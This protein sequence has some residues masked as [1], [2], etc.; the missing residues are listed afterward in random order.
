MGLRLIAGISRPSTGMSNLDVAKT[1]LEQLGGGRFIAMTGARDFLGDANSLKFRLPKAKD[2]I[3]CVQITLE[4]SDTY[5]VK[6]M[7]IGDRRT[8]YRVT[9]KSVHE[10][11]YFDQ[12][13]ELF[14]RQTGL[15]THL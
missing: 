2:G 15:Y 13:Q 6:F 4:P 10:D 7:R 12:L 8:M 9:E 1:I 11:I 3:N 5:T 14:T